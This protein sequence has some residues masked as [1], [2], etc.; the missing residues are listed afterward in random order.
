[1]FWSWKLLTFTEIEVFVK[2]K[3]NMVL[4]NLS[5]LKDYWLTYETLNLQFF[6]NCLVSVIE[7]TDSNYSY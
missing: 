1:M 2:L 3:A 5:P 7:P 4:V 6:I